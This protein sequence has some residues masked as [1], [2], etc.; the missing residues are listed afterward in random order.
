LRA[1][2]HWR[3]IFQRAWRV[4][5]VEIQRATLRLAGERLPVLLATAAP[6]SSSWSGLFPSRVDLG[7][8]VIREGRVHWND[9][10]SL[11]GTTI[12]LVPK[13]GAW[14]IDASGG[15]LS[16]KGWPTVQVED[17]QMRFQP[18]VLHLIGSH[19]RTSDG[20]KAMVTGTLRAPLALRADVERIPLTP[21]L[22][23]DW[24]AQVT[25]K[26]SGVIHVAESTEG[27]PEVN[28]S[29]TLA[30]GKAEALPVLD[31][32]ALF[33][34]TRQFRSLTLQKGSAKFSQIGGMLTVTDLNVES[35]RLLRVTGNLN[36][37]EGQVDGVL[38]VGVT[39]SSLQ[40]LP[41]SQEK[42]FNAS[43]DGYLWTTVKVS[44]PANHPH[45]DLTVRLAQA[46]GEKA[47]ENV[48]G[49]VRETTKTVIDLLA[50]LVR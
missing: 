37:K 18:P 22:S 42:V 15:T 25:G 12:T 7:Q 8:V 21:F 2:V 29:L 47:I 24:R 9:D 5:H 1:D 27:A 3:D 43:H 49:T 46:A 32:I 28:G 30:D 19:F 38:Q 11:S 6:M 4:D 40:W 45:E 48:D 23:E 44:G 31:Q 34:G 17:A 36:L 35:E 16:Q 50:P 39:E 10:G 33:T 14:A 26:I 41:G 20:G 13:D